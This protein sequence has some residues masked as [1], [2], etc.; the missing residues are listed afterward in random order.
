M[1][2]FYELLTMKKYQAS[3]LASVK[4]RLLLDAFY[5]VAH[6]LDVDREMVPSPLS[7][8][9]AKFFVPRPEDKV[10]DT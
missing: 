4:T 10:Q 2:I 3:V 9:R 7:V 1:S 5:F 8:Q 6:M